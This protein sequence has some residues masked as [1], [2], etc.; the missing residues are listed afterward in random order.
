MYVATTSDEANAADGPFSTAWRKY[1]SRT[2]RGTGVSLPHASRSSSA[3]LRKVSEVR[4]GFAAGRREV[5]HAS[6]HDEAPFDAYHHGGD[7]DYDVLIER[8][9]TAWA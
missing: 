6:T 3:E 5:R 8:F 9:R 2:R 4:H 7:H 1:E